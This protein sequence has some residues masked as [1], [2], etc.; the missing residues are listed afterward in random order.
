[1]KSQPKSILV[2][3]GCGFI[4]SNFINHIAN[5]WLHA[6]ITCLDKLEECSSLRNVKRHVRASPNYQFVHGDIGN[7]DL[8]AKI[9][10]LKNVDTVFHFAAMSHV[11]ESYTCK[12]ILRKQCPIS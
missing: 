4:G 6:N 3:G 9:L 5:T 1:M 11:D 2:T 7:K 8:V 10:R 12:F